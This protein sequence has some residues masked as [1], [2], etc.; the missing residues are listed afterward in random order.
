MSTIRVLYKLRCRPGDLPELQ[1]AW[2][3][4]VQA[5]ARAG[6]QT[7]ESVLLVDAPDAPAAPDDEHA[8]LPPDWIVATAISRWQSRQAWES[9]RT[10]EVD[11]AA[12]ARF[13]ELCTVDEKIVFEELDL[14]I[15]GLP[16][17]DA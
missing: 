6:H 8:S 11:Q 1:K 4:V 17:E 15:G 5:H 16:P 12:Y 3:A 10:D 2:R 9:Q 13:R 7:L 14:L